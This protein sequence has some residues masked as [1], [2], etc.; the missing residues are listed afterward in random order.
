MKRFVIESIHNYLL[1]CFTQQK[2]RQWN[3]NNSSQ[4]IVQLLTEYEFM[5]KQNYLEK[6]K[7]VDSL[8]N[9]VLKSIPRCVQDRVIK[10]KTTKKL[11]YMR[12]TAETF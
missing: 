2:P 6:D 5:L 8:R 7:I 4:G 9:I 11:G 1:M 12:E 3:I 10:V